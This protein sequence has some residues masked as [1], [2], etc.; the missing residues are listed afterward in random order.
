M[1]I[2]EFSIAQKKPFNL[3]LVFELFEGSKFDKRAFKVIDENRRLFAEAKMDNDVFRYNL[4]GKM[5]LKKF[6]TLG[7]DR[8]TILN[9]VRRLLE[10][11]EF[12]EL[13]GMDKK[14]IIY[15]SDLVLV[16]KETEEV[17]V[18]IVP[19]S[20]H[21][22]MVK[23]LRAFLKEIIAN[24]IYEEEENLDYVGRLIN[25]INSNKEIIPGRME[26]V[27]GGIEAASVR[28]NNVIPMPTVVAEAPEQSAE[29][30]G[31]MMTEVPVT[32]QDDT[33]LYDMPEK[34]EEP[35]VSEPVIEE[36]VVEEVVEAPVVET[37]IIEEMAVEEPV[38]EEPVIEAPVIEAPVIEEPVAAAPVVSEPVAAAPIVEAPVSEDTY[39]EPPKPVKQIKKFPYLV[40]SKNQEIV[41]IDKDEFKIGK[42]P[43][44]ADYLLADNPAVSRMHAIIQHVENGYYICDN[45][46]TNSTYLNG[47]RLEPGKR[48]ILLNGVRVLIANEEF[49]YL[50]EK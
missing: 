38:A 12:F 45:Y 3:T 5:S 7:M 44:M 25:Y 36:P 22:L 47:E 19:A 35:V 17:T 4:T 20:D 13:N 8:E 50:M 21:G 26:A 6:L 24:A 37:P 42:I 23:P 39:V 14:Y 31:V 49:T 27:L 41:I 33:R 30:L 15:D 40:R 48:Y 43:G 2:R 18:V 9:I 11:E 34:V 32:P 46:S 10:V 28:P 16:D 29:E 1:N